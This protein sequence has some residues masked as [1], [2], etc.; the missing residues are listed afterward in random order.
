MGCTSCYPQSNVAL[1][2]VV[3]IL[4]GGFALSE[5]AAAMLAHSLSLAGDA[6]SMG[7][8]TMTYLLNSV[9][10]RYKAR[11]ASARERLQLELYI[12]LVSA[13]AL[14][15]ASGMI[16]SQALSTLRAP[17]AVSSAHS[18]VMLIF[19]SVNLIIDAVA[20]VFFRR[21]QQLEAAVHRAALGDAAA[22]LLP[23]QGAAPL[24]PN[25]DADLW[26]GNFNLCSAF[27][28]V[29]ADTLRSISVLVA[30]LAARAGKVDADVA[31]AWA[32]LSVSVIIVISL[33]PLLRALGRNAATLWCGRH[34][35]S[36]ALT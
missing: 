13:L 11:G 22:P 17:P 32:G 2:V 27:T 23:D 20:V 8:D 34:S 21:V 26:R 6:A 31:D 1:L 3:S 16:V 33:L 12:P 24:L 7:V 14:L 15:C 19:S 10:E 4:F 29:L 35:D 28:H 25:G 30:A 5:G 18:G 36:T 9:A